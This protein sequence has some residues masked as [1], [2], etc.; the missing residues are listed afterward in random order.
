[1]FVMYDIQMSFNINRGPAK[2][3]IFKAITRL[4]D[5]SLLN[6]LADSKPAGSTEIKLTSLTIG[7]VPVTSEV[8][9]QLA[10]VMFFL[11]PQYLMVALFQYLQQTHLELN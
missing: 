8:A 2:K 7:N 9:T 10:P 3:P 5:N 6:Q 1:M 11:I 4:N